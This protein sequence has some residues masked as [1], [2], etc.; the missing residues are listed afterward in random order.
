MGAHSD[1]R[2][3]PRAGAFTTAERRLVTAVGALVGVLLLVEAVGGRS[4]K[5]TGF[6]DN[7]HLWDWLHLL[8]LPVTLALLPVL[9]RRRAGRRAVSLAVLGAV[10]VLFLVVVV[11]G[12]LVPWSWTGFPGTTLWDWLELLLLPVSVA[13]LPFVLESGAMRG[14]WFEG[15]TIFLLTFALLALPGYLVPWTWTGFTGN[16]LWDWVELLVVPFALPVTVAVVLHH[17]AQRPD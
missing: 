2:R 1:T 5:W 3:S 9:T 12:F 15:A 6:D 13:L 8:L 16:T 4:W 17:S 7:Q 10:A 11:A 14:R